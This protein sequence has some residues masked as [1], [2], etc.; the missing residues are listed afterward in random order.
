MDAHQKLPK[1]KIKTVKVYLL[2]FSDRK[3]VDKTFD[4]SHAQKQMEFITQPT[5]HGYTV[6]IVWRTIR[7]KGKKRVVI[8]IQSNF[9]AAIISCQYTSV[10][11][12][13]GFFH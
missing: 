7:K 11:D 3:I 12:A 13:A 2:G 9:F 10:F 6:F 8:D 5:F 1:V 4:K